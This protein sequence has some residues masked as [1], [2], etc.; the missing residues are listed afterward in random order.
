MLQPT[1]GGAVD[2]KQF[3]ASL[4][5]SLAWPI[6]VVLLAAIFRNQIR[7]KLSQIKKF[8]AAGVNFEISE[9]VKEVQKAG[10]AVELEQAD[11]PR[12]A[13]VLDPGLVLLAKNFPE[14]AV[15]QSFKDV[16]AVLLRIRQRLPS[17]KP[18][19][20]LN[21]VLNALANDSQ[22]SQNVITL[23][24]RLRQARNIAAHAKDGE[25]MA[26]GEAIE[27]VG[28]MKNLQDLLETVLSKLPPKSTRI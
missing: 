13:I 20:N 12:D 24:Q 23:F 27:L 9:Q 10:E 2:W 8:G 5:G 1:L 26:P 25:N 14:A 19:R 21:E 17:D 11:E 15:L 3:V 6:A 16:E 28:Q 22:I 7:E 4:I 18:H